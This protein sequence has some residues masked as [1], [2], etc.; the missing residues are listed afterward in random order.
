MKEYSVKETKE[1]LGL[2]FALGLAIKGAKLDGKV[3][4]DDL[5]LLVPLLPMVGA[6]MDKL[7]E[8]PNEL[9]EL[10]E[11]E[12]SELLLFSKEKIAGLVDDE[13]S[14]KVVNAALGV[15]VSIAELVAV[16]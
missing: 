4:A 13:H 15:A 10:D 6:A 14:K 2:C 12:K 1:L 7:G 5:L 8:I 9:S 3:G 11:S 16:I